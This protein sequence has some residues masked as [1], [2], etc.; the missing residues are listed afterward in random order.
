[1][2]IGFGSAVDPPET[3]RFWRGSFDLPATGRPVDNSAAL[4]IQQKRMTDQLLWID[5]NRLCLGAL[6]RP[7]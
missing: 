4:V 7:I 5:A 6:E 1:M 3:V 2:P